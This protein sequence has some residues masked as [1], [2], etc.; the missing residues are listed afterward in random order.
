MKVGFAVTLFF[1]S[2]WTYSQKYDYRWILGARYETGSHDV[3]NMDVIFTQN[4][5]DTIAST[6]NVFMENSQ[7]TISDSSANLLFYTNG[8]R[9]Y[10]STNDTMQNGDSINYGP[11]WNQYDGEFYPWL[12]DI[13]AL[14]TDSP[15]IWNMIHYYVDINNNSDIVVYPWR[16]KQTQINI[17]KNSGQG[18][19]LFKNKTLIQDTL[20]TYVTACKH[21][22]GRDW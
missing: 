6:R 13:M 12:N 2:N 5:V 4:S 19:V 16:I 1:I 21:A 8:A 17:S 7:T 3:G 10:T 14:P 15:E 9:I 20:G 18:E 22:N 11:E